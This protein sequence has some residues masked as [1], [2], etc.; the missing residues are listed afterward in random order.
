[1]L[2]Y[3]RAKENRAR[4][5]F[6]RERCY[7]WGIILRGLGERL[8]G[9]QKVMGSSPTISTSGRLPHPIRPSSCNAKVCTTGH[10]FGC[11]AECSTSG[12]LPHPIRLSWC[13]TKVFATGRG[14]GCCAE[15]STKKNNQS[16][17]IG[18]SFYF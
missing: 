11:C 13:K 10:E 12:K 8:T 3:Q 16:Q 2:N 1:M 7:L 5:D 9:S 17:R 6:L 14:F 4:R 15:C 18:C